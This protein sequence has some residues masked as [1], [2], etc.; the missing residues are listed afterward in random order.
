MKE[1]E[2]QDILRASYLNVGELGEEA[3]GHGGALLHGGNSDGFVHVDNIV[4]G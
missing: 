2:S 4:D 3:V 1:T